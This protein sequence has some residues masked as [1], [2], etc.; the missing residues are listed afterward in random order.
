MRICFLVC[1][2]R[3]YIIQNMLSCLQLQNIDGEIMPCRQRHD[4]DKILWILPTTMYFTQ[5]QHL[6]LDKIVR[7]IDER[8]YRVCYSFHSSYTELK[9]L[10]SYLRPVNV[11]PNVKPPNDSKLAVVSKPFPEMSLVEKNY[12]NF[13]LTKVSE[14]PKHVHLSI[15]SFF[16]PS[17]CW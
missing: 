3:N 1:S 7:K 17:H 2:Y 11:Y 15:K 14:I 10:I 5:F 13:I 16:H 6:T 9:D 8:F 4:S 12:H